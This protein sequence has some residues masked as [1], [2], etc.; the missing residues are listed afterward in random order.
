[1]HWVSF[2]RVTVRSCSA[3]RPSSSGYIRIPGSTGKRVTGAPSASTIIHI[4]G[5]AAG[6]SSLAQASVPRKRNSIPLPVQSSAGGC[7]SGSILPISRIPGV[8]AVISSV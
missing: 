2:I 6:A 1:M 4:T 3:S 7:C 5:A 8:E